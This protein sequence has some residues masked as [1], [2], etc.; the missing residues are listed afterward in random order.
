ML[1]LFVLVL[2]SFDS[3]EGFSPVSITTDKSSGDI[4]EGD[5]IV[6][7]L[8]L[9][10]SDTRYRNMEVYM[11]ANWSSG[12]A[13]NSTFVD[14][15]YDELDNNLI[16]MGKAEQATIN[17]M[18]ICEGSCSA[19]DTNELRIY[20]LTDPRFYLTDY[21]EGE[22]PGN[23]TD[24]CGSAD[25]KNDTTPASSSANRTNI[26]SLN[27]N[28]RTGYTSVIACD[29]VASIGDNVFTP[30]ETYLWGY[31]LTNTGWLSDSYRFDVD[32]TSKDGQDVWYWEFDAGI[33]DGK[34][35]TGQS[36]SSS[37]AVHS[38]EASMSIT[39]AT[40][41]TSGV[42]NVELTV[43]S[44]G[45]G[46]D[47][48]CNFDVVI[49][50]NETAEEETISIS[51]NVPIQDDYSYSDETKITDS[52]VNWDSM[53][54]AF[55]ENFT[56]AFIANNLVNGTEYSF[57]YEIISAH[58]GRTLNSSSHIFIANNTEEYSYNLVG[59]FP[60]TDQNNCSK[61]QAKVSFVKNPNSDN[62]TQKELAS[63]STDN[64]RSSA[65]KREICNPPINDPGFYMSSVSVISALISIGLIAIF[66]RK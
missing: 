11:V 2:S 27:L 24:S 17:I 28:A 4:L 61:V 44:A 34:A 8:T 32:V 30:G 25:C 41:A 55:G 29:A 66:R 40:N 51:V 5:S 33:L 7:T 36:N 26:I 65:Y 42:Y 62:G 9:D 1:G 47:A 39:P 16:R 20:G 6:F 53:D 38:I 57:S 63:F 12:I 19:G 56:F 21:G 50:A 54:I 64:F 31:N 60:Y 37:S 35:L 13:W 10:N 49:P 22:D 58:H 15:N 14:S 46:A 48:G 59:Q 18:I 45:G 23:H 3:A 52:E 43:T